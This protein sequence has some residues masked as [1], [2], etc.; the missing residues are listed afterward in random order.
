MNSLA[1]S[2]FVS[3]LSQ[4]PLSHLI[5]S[6]LSHTSCLLIFL[7][8]FC[9]FH[10]SVLLGLSFLCLACLTLTCLVSSC[11]ISSLLY[12]TSL[13]FSLFLTHL[14]LFSLVS[15]CVSHYMTLPFTLSHTYPLISLHKSYLYIHFLFYTQLVSSDIHS[16][17][18]IYGQI[19]CKN[20]KVEKT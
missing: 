15:L 10:F 18:L 4:Y 20:S 1:L 11:F 19:H 8:F 14:I 16:S 5:H 3:F 17:L 9:S 7:C 13:V 2:H 6:D 12:S